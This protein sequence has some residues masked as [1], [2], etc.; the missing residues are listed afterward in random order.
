MMRRKSGFGECQVGCG[1]GDDRAKRQEI[2]RQASERGGL[3]PCPDQRHHLARTKI[4]GRRQFHGSDPFSVS[5]GDLNSP[6]GL[7]ER[8]NWLDS[9]IAASAPPP[10]ASALSDI[11]KQCSRRPRG[12][13]SPIFNPLETTTPSWISP[14]T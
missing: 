2:A 6:A 7:S 12:S 13:M 3:A 1:G 8:R 11:V 5:A 4:E 9:R 10:T 14:R